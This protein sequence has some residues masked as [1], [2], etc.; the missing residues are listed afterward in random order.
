[1][2]LHHL[3]VDV[4][5]KMYIINPKASTTIIDRVITNKPTR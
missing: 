3:E 5:L 4:K 1:M 2:I